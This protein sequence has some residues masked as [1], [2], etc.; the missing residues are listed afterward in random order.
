MPK[1]LRTATSL[2]PIIGK[3]TLQIIDS[4]RSNI[5]SKSKIVT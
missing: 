2:L 5:E 4:N 1:P 3:D